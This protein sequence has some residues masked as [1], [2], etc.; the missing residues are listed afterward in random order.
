M[1]ERE[2]YSFAADGSYRLGVVGLT[3]TQAD[4]INYFPETFS[5][6]SFLDEFE[7]VATKEEGRFSVTLKGGSQ[8][9]FLRGN[10]FQ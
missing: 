2:L 6:Q 7:S 3:I 8:E 5:R 4:G 9:A 10:C 1:Q